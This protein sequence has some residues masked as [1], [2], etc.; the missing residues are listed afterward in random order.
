[1]LPTSAAGQCDPSGAISHRMQTLTA[2][3][4]LRNGFLLSP[5]P[6]VMLGTIP[7]SWLEL[8]V[9]PLMPLWPGFAINT[10]FYAAILWLLFAFPFALRRRRRIKRGLCP[11]CAYPVG[12]SA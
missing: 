1:M 6:R 10:V 12:D 5:H 2:V 11:A 8:R 3:S 9:L 7:F 4:D